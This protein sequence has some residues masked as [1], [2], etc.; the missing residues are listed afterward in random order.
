MIA[1]VIRFREIFRRA[2]LPE[3]P[4][5]IIIKSRFHQSQRAVWG[6]FALG[7]GFLRETEFAV[8]PSKKTKDSAGL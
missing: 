3:E 6:V 1:I 4:S 8:G 2:H 7:S 5:S